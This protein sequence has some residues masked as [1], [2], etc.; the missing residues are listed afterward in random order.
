[1]KLNN[2]KK[3]QINFTKDGQHMKYIGVSIVYHPDGNI[4]S[5]GRNYIYGLVNEFYEYLDAVNEEN[6]AENQK[7][8]IFYEQRR[9]A[10]KI[11]FIRAIEGKNGIEKIR[12]RLGENAHFLSE[13]KLIMPDPLR[14]AL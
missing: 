9:I 7:E 12:R 2:K 5:V 10:G 6:V 11:A 8:H 13:E 14:N 3:R 1:M 4:L